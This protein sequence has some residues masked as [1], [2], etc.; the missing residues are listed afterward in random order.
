MV[1]VVVVVGCAVVDVEVDVD[2]VDEVVVVVPPPVAAD[3]G[4]VVHVNPFGS[5]ADVVKVTWASQY[6]SMA[7]ALL[8]QASPVSQTGDTQGW[9]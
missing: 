5:P 8:K 4:V 7:P 6:W 3:P 9:Q 2:D 1:D